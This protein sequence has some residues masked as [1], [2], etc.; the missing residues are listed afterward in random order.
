MLV[1]FIYTRDAGGNPIAIERESALGVFYYAYDKLQRLVYEGQFISAV[2]QYENYYEYDPAGNRTFLRHGETGAENLSYYGYDAANELTM[3]HDQSGWSYFYYDQNGNTVT[4]QTPSYTRYYD[5]DGRDMLVGVRSTEAGW[6]DNVYRYDG[7]ASRVSTLESSGFTYYDWDA[8]NVLQEKDGQG[9]VTSRQVHG[10]A[11]ITNVG[12]IAL[13]DMAGTPYVVLADQVGTTSNLLD[14]TGAKANSYTYDAF[15]VARSV[16]ETVPN[17]YRFGTKR[18]DPDPALYHFIARQYDAHVGLHASRERLGGVCASCSPYSYVSNMPLSVVDPSGLWKIKRADAGQAEA[19]SECCDTIAGLAAII[20]LD[21]GSW[22][23]WLYIPAW[24]DTILLCPFG[25]TDYL[26]L[27]DETKL[28]ANQVFRIPNTIYAH[29]AG[30]VP[31]LGLGKAFVHWRRDLH[32]L[33]Q[34]GFSVVVRQGGTASELE[35][36]LRSL[37]GA[38]KALHGIFFWG[39]GNPQEVLTEAD[40][41]GDAH[42]LSTFEHWRESLGYKPAFGLV[43]ACESSAARP[44]FSENAIFWGSAGRLVPCL[45]R[46]GHIIWEIGCP[47]VNSLIPPGA[48]GTNG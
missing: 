48:Q 44:V 13:M 38:Q 25:F 8:I 1:Q 45:F 6:T 33:R 19:R 42:Y 47:T 26:H 2:R 3:V 34:R 15:G 29:W 46:I 31:W 41:A 40:M 18:L 43:C 35:S 24:S 20:G 23:S 30:T 16:S 11:P 37:S 27:T 5:W 4:E 28:A 14:A 12:D 7:L 10:Y 39:H 17:R 9:S 32:T 36:S 22:E 21:A